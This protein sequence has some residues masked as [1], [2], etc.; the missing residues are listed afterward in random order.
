MAR[1]AGHRQGKAAARQAVTHI[2][3][4]VPDPANRRAHNPRNLGMVADALREVGAA[5]SIVIDEDDVILAGNGVTEAAAEAGITKVRVVEA[6]GDEIIAVR[7]S[8]LSAEQK[9]A[10]AIYDNRTGELATWDFE[11][12]AADVEAGLSLQPFW[13]EEEAVAL[14]AKHGGRADGLT[15][16]DDVPEERPTDIV[17]GDLFELGHHRVMCGDS[18][19]GVVIARLLDGEPLDLLLTDPPYGVSV[20]GKSGKI[21]GSVMAKNQVYRPVEGD[22]ES[23]DPS[24]LFLISQ[25]AVVW[26]ANYFPLLLPHSGQ[27][28]VWDKGR[29]EGTTFSDCELAWTS[30]SGVAVKKYSCVWNG[31]TREGESG[32]R[33]HPTQKPVKLFSE[34]MADFSKDGDT[35]GDWYLGSGTSLVAAEQI[36]RKCRG[37]EL[38]PR[39]C[40]VIIDRWEAFTGQKAVKVGELVRA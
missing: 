4:L 27:W 6:S 1:P 19:D 31:M 5:R 30:R 8:G 34:V 28:I 20:V 37:V 36:G 12:L 16:P 21:G 25:T 7:R 40:Q 17:S 29:P 26:G 11:Q 24:H 23:F 33:V 32:K 35:V 2:K 9:R 10:L 13:T 18:R 22:S 15:D 38:D 39:Y 14:L 3:Q